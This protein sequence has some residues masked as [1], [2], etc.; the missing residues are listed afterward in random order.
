MREVSNNYFTARTDITIICSEGVE[1][2]CGEG[3]GSE[4]LQEAVASSL[5]VECRYK[6]VSNV[7]DTCSRN[8]LRI[9]YA[10]IL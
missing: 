10:R 4:N 8:D 9:D 1:F 5:A 6:R 7:W 2:G 3:K